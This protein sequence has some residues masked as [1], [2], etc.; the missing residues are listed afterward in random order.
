MAAQKPG[1]PRGRRK[2][3]KNIPYGQAHVKTSFN[4]TIVSLTDREVRV[5]HLA[6]LDDLVVGE[7]LDVSVRRHAG[8]GENLVRGRAANPVDVGEAD[9]GALVERD[10]D[11]CDASH[12]CDETRPFGRVSGG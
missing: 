8:F 5:D 11:A 10:V 3:K 9:L 2:V 1:R 6:Q 4:N 7:V 12:C